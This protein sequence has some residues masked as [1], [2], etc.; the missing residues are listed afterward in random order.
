MRARPLELLS[1]RKMKVSTCGK[2]GLSVK[3]ENDDQEHVSGWARQA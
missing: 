3:Q 1:R 2:E